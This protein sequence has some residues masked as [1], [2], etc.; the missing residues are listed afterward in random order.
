MNCGQLNTIL[1]NF[2]CYSP[3]NNMKSES[4]ENLE[5]KLLEGFDNYQKFYDTMI[6]EEFHIT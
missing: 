6:S 2:F 5:K 3:P 4:F 1:R